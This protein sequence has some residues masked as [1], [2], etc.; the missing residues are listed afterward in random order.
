MTLYLASGTDEPYMKDEAR[1]L[2]VERYFDGG[3]YGALDDYKSFSKGILIRRIIDSAAFRGDE[4]LAFGDG[5]V[6]I[7]EVKK[8]GGIAVGAATEEPEC[9]VI[10]EW[11]RSRLI[12]VGADMIV[13]NFLEHDALLA[14]LFPR[15]GGEYL[16]LKEGYHPLVAFLFGWASLLMIQGGGFAAVA[17]AFAQ[18]TLRLAGASAAHANPVAL[19]AIAVVALVNCVGV[20]PGGRLLD[21][22]VLLKIGALALLIA[23]GLFLASH[24]APVASTAASAAIRP[25]LLGFG[26]ALIPILFSYGGWQSANILS[27]EIRDPRSTLPRAL[28]AGTAIVV[29]VYLLANVVY[30]KTLSREGLAATATPAAEAAR[31]IFG[32]GADRLI[33]A[34]IAVSAFG[35]LD[36]TLLAPTR[37]YYAM[38]RDGLFFESLSRLHPRFGTP[39]LAIAAQA[40]WGAILVLTGTYGDLVDSVVFGDWIFFGLTVGALFLFR[41]RFPPGSRGRGSFLTP[42]YPWVPAV[43]VVAAALVVASAIRTSPG[44]ALFG[45][46]LLATGVPAY[47][48]FARRARA[49][50]A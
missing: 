1:L 28:L 11:K 21:V 39:S 31:R 25:S 26:A 38:A 23:G 4:F 24:P 35:F 50:A 3:V 20:K 48:F 19:A 18:Y 42:G 46:V 27:E 44:R 8:V 13:P 37:I 12:G 47:F 7:E 17:I 22:L 41:R 45:T 6:E 15:V 29:A 30:L 10:D 43:F 9:R 2:D 34:A 36:L 14:T 32:P 16:Y 33:A 5:Y 40:A 49:K